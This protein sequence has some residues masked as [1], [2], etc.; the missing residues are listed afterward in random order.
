MILLL[1]NYDSFTYNLYQLLAVLGEEVEVVRNDVMNVEALNNLK[2]DYLVISP[3]PG[4]PESAGI[5]IEAVKYFAGKIPILGVCLGHQ[6][7]TVAYGGDVIQAKRLMHGKVS[8]LS[9]DNKGLF[10]SLPPKIAVMRY[11]S[12]LTDEGTLPSELIVTART[13]D[14]EVMAVQHTSL[15]VFGVQFHPEAYLTEYGAA[16]MRNF[17]TSNNTL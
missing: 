12:L 10:A 5:S 9:H 13:T 11:H 17:L 3:G 6:A 4:K 1:D 14:D 15:P 7:I 8:Y 2:P 16:I